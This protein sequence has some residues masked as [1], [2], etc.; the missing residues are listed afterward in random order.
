VRNREKPPKKSSSHPPNFIGKKARHLDWRLGLP[1]G[2]MK[3]LFPN[4]FI[5]QFGVLPSLPAE[6]WDL[7]F[8]PNS[9]ET[10]PSQ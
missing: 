8:N 2:C 6:L 3:F 10:N 7:S 4:Q 1:I 5:T 9:S